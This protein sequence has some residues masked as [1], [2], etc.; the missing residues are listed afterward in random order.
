MTDRRKRRGPAALAALILLSALGS[1]ARRAEAGYT[2]IDLGNFGTSAPT[3][4]GTGIN[5]SG[6]VTGYTSV[7]GGID[8]FVA[9]GG[10]MTAIPSL[11]S[12]FS[13]AYGI[14][15]AGQIVGISGTD[16]FLYSGGTLTDLTTVDHVSFSG[17]TAQ[18]TAINDSGWIVGEARNSGGTNDAFVYA[19]GTLTNLSTLTNGAAG[20]AFAINATGQIAGQMAFSSGTFGF[21]YTGGNGTH[22]TGG[23]IAKLNALGT[24]SAALD[25]NASGEVAGYYTSGGMT[26]AFLYNG[27]SMSD[28]T[29]GTPYASIASEAFG[30]NDSGAIVGQLI[31]GTTDSGFL[32]SGGTLTNLSSVISGWTITG[33]YGINDNGQIAVVATNNTTNQMHALLLSQTALVPEPPTIALL[34]SGAVAGL[35]LRRFA[36]RR[37][38]AEDLTADLAVE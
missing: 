17:S 33:A 1:A 16:A 38:K 15:T 13:F 36:R 35:G 27:T 29:T 34:C 21:V 30:L 12:S 18:A 28:I 24:S 11:G 9:N 37:I 10:T 2:F 19:G 20:Q 26:H 8:G 25:I 23:T 6:E 32:Y 4:A 5:A 22:D 3:I 14:N 31:S 7:V